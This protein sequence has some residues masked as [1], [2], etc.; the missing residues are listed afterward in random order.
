MQLQLQYAQF[1]N[2]QNR[3]I[4][5]EARVEGPAVVFVLARAFFPSPIRVIVVV[6]D[7][8]VRDYLFAYSEEHHA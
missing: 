6:L 7:L 3:V 4:L 2:R 5:S 8:P 1:C